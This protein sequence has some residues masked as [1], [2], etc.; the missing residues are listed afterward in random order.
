MD[1]AMSN[2]AILSVGHA[3]FRVKRAAGRDERV[4]VVGGREDGG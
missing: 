1:C 2:G 3:L 4:V